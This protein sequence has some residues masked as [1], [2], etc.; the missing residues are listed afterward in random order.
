MRTQRNRP[1]KLY[2]DS[3]ESIASQHYLTTGEWTHTPSWSCYLYNFDTG[4][5]ASYSVLEYDKLRKIR[6]MILIVLWTCGIIQYT[7][8]CLQLNQR[9]SWTPAM[10][11][12]NVLS[13]SY[14]TQ[15]TKYIHNSM[16]HIYCTEESKC[17]YN[18]SPT[19]TPRR[20]HARQRE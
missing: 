7:R 4:T 13:R 20:K 5:L 15:H 3:R 12:L 6:L 10:T 8:Q 9:T 16:A 1:F 17:R 2:R 11:K 14:Y 18:E 19:L